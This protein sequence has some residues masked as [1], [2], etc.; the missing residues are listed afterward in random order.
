MCGFAPLTIMMSLRQTAGSFQFS[1]FIEHFANKLCSV[2]RLIITGDKLGKILLEIF[3]KDLVKKTDRTQ[4]NADKFSIEIPVFSNFRKECTVAADG[5]D[6]LN[7]A[8]GKVSEK[9]P[10]TS[11]SFGHS[12]SMPVSK[13]GTAPRP[14]RI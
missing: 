9:T 14:L 2:Y 5:D 8:L 10:G 11:L 6:R 3:I 7:I 1:V 13:T 12:S 4:I